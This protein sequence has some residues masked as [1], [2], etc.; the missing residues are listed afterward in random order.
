MSCEENTS[1]EKTHET[2]ETFKCQTKIACLFLQ[3]LTSDDTQVEAWK[4]T[5]LEMELLL[6]TL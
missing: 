1:V 2:V 4:Q 3:I 5:L 6:T